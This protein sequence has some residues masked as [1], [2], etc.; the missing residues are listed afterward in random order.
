[1]VSV[2]WY[3]RVVL[4]SICHHQHHHHDGQ[5]HHHYHYQFINIITV[6][7]LSLL[8]MIIAIIIIFFIDVV[9]YNTVSLPFLLSSHQRCCHR[10]AFIFCVLVDAFV[11]LFDFRLCCWFIGW[12]GVFVCF[13]CSLVQV[14]VLAMI[15]KLGIYILINCSGASAFVCT[16]W[17]GSWSEYCMWWMGARHLLVK[18]TGH[19]YHT[20]VSFWLKGQDTPTTPV[21]P[22]G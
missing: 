6:V 21:C 10:S 15:Q 2:M 16:G 14:V 13:F 11:C 9:P 3:L 4:S 8:I 18:G 7:I 20:S 12:V 22:S 5:H 19:T 17:G 1:M